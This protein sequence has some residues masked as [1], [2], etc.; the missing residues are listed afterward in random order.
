M[1]TAWHRKN[2]LEK[3]AKLERRMAWHREHQEACACR[4]IPPKLVAQMESAAGRGS[5]VD[6]RFAPVLASLS[7]Q[8]RVTYGGKGFGSTGLKVDGKLFAMMSSRGQFVVK[9]PQDRVGELV[10]TGKA[11]LFDPGHGRLMKEW[12]ALDGAASSWVN[13]AKEAHTYV[14]GLKPSVRPRK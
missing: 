9:L 13:L 2:V 12:A 3:S 8:P 11:E 1:N 6:G 4:P 10:R 7:R 5:R 14:S